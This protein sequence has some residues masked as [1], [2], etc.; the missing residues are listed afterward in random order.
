[1]IR[2]YSRTSVKVSSDS[3]TVWLEYEDAAEFLDA[4]ERQPHRLE[5]IAAQAVSAGG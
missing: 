1:M 4:I 5:T 2:V 3:A